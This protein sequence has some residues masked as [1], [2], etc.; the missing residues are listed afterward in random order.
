MPVIHRT[1]MRQSA[2][3]NQL[4]GANLYFKMENLQ[5]TGSFKLRGA[6]NKVMSLTDE[7]AARGIIAAS[8]GN[9]AQGVALSAAKRGVKAKIYMPEKTPLAKVNATQSYGAEAVLI[10]ES[11][12]EAY[13]AAM[14]DQEENDR[15]FVHAFDDFDVMAGQ[16]TL[17]LEMMQQAPDLGTI[18]VPV[19][20]G[21][22][23]SGIAALIKSIYPG[24]RVVGV[25]S[26][27][28]AATFNR[29]TGKGSARLS[30]VNSIADGI[31]VKETGMITY[32]IIQ[33]FVDDMVTVTDA[34]IALAMVMMLER[35]KAFVE[36]AG[37]A[38]L[39]AVLCGKLALKGKKAGIII[40]GG[41][42]DVAK[43]PYYKS[44][45]KPIE[46]LR[47]IG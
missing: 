6:L 47:K 33:H 16:G 22:L 21:G 12:Q 27:G 42:A 41:N 2:T 7:E 11:Y 44:L 45:A 14:R 20:G 46:N 5:R 19:G 37:A 36:G 9:H 24:V 23:I 17:A 32:P 18:V 40:S 4:T 3:F 39:A 30:R 38:A 43:F 26:S 29:F 28:A 8:A 13:E 31:A 10:G 15:A 1:P 35:E 34:E 25:Q